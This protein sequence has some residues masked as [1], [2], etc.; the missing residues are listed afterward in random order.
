MNATSSA[1]GSLTPKRCLICLNTDKEPSQLGGHSFVET[2]C[3]KHLLCHLECLYHDNAK[4]GKSV[5]KRLCCRCGPGMSLTRNKEPLLEDACKK[6]DLEALKMGLA[7]KPEGDCTAALSAVAKAVAEASVSGHNDSK[8]F[9][10]CFRTLSSAIQNH[11]DEHKKL[12]AQLATLA[13]GVGVAIAGLTKVETAAVSAK[14][15]ALCEI[16][17]EIA[18]MYITG[19]QMGT[20]MS[21][22][23]FGSLLSSWDLSAFPHTIASISVLSGSVLLGIASSDLAYK[24]GENIGKKMGNKIYLEDGNTPLHIA[25]QNDAYQCVKAL[26]DE[27]AGRD[28]QKMRIIKLAF[29]TI[30]N[31][32]SSGISASMPGFMERLSDSYND[33]FFLTH[34]WDV[35]TTNQDGYTPLHFAAENNSV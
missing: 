11:A 8:D 9:T 7:L 20:V 32:I 33:L 27:W 16:V 14:F 35:N 18:N 31:A 34:R 4:P 21:M 29:S 13:T 6:G 15:V 19:F 17:G 26:V 28:Q 12:C 1:S 2:N 22:F 25:S 24:S 23:G 5:I 3:Q 10:E 30:M